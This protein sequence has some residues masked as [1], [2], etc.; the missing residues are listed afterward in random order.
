MTGKILLISGSFED[1]S[2]ITSGENIEKGIKTTDDSHYPLGIAYLH[3]YLE[4][5]G[6]KVESLFLNNLP[7]DSCFNAV[8]D[9]LARFLPDV[10][11]IQILTPNRISSYRIIE[12]IHE[13]YPDL[14]IA[15][16]GIHTTIM[17]EQLLA[18]YPFLVTVLGEGEITFGE[19]V[20]EVSKEKPLLEKVDGIAFKKNGSIIKTGQRALIEN[21]DSLP[22]PKHEIFFNDNR[23]TG[24]LIT[25]RGCPFACTYCCLDAISNRKTRYR[26]VK[27]VVDEIEFLINKNGNLRSIWLHDDT[28]FLNNQR[29]VEL[30][31]EIMDRGIKLEFICS[32]RVKPLSEEVVVMMERAGFK[33]VLL[34]LESGDDDILKE[35][36]KNITRKDVLRAF[37]LFSKT[38]IELYAFLIV[39]LPGETAVTVRNTIKFVKKLQRIKYIY[40]AEDIAVLTVYPGTA[41]YEKAKIAGTLNDDY[42]LLDKPTPLYTA[43]H[44]LRQLHI[45]KSQILD[46]VSFDRFFTPRGFFAQ[47]F[48]APYILAYI[49][50]HRILGKNII[51]LFLY[52]LMKSLIPERAYEVMVRPYRYFKQKSK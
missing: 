44:S 24:C 32:G 33:K 48:M 8:V 1:V 5:C 6:H 47:F 11:G 22:F 51:E 17:Y 30:C 35:C 49:V 46:N 12:Y 20:E 31:S 38:S 36:K 37:R 27:N 42:W 26:S 40:Y 41:I 10:V 45:F 4:A 14:W 23:T 25:S 34:G 28:L 52:K 39:G 2:L 29:V 50:R 3:S 7:F 9:S 21:L 18:R 43:E 19:F 16:G 15:A 13:R